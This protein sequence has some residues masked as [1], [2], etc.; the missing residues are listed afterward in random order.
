MN[1]RLKTSKATA[2]R[3]KFLQDSTRLT[4]NI[5]ARYAVILSLKE[6]QPILKT[7]KDVSGTDFLRNVLTGPY[8]YL[9]KVLI[10]QHENR[11]ITDEEYF[12]GLFN[13][14]LERGCILLQ[15]EYNYAGNYEKLIT[16]LIFK[17]PEVENNDIPG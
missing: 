12:P 6:R 13:N 14:H 10:A 17:V 16:N 15:N 2:E 7:V 11:E 5:I 1:F 4:P 3:L 8:D 9:F